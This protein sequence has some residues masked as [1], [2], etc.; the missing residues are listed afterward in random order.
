M[1]GQYLRSG[2][3]HFF[4]RLFIFMIRWSSCHSALCTCSYSQLWYRSNK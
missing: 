3:D 2:D 4:P 1:L